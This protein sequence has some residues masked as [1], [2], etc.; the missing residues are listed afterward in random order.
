M[1][2]LGLPLV[3]LALLLVS[4][5]AGCGQQVQGLPDAVQGEVKAP[6]D[7]P[8]GTYTLVKSW[9]AYSSPHRIGRAVDD[10]DAAGGKALEAQLEQ[11]D[12]E[13][14]LFGPYLEDL[15][16]GNYVAFYRMKLLTPA[17]DDTLGPVDACVSY[18]QDLLGSR[19]LAADDLTLGKY[20]QVPLGFHYQSGKLE[21]R[22]TWQGTAGIRID[23]VSLFRLEGG[24]PVMHQWLVPQAVP[25]GEPK[26]LPYYTEPKSFP[27]IFP[28]SAAPAK[29]MLVC[30]LRKQ[31]TDVRMLIYTLQGLINRSQPRL[32]CISTPQ[33]E[34]WL[35]HMRKRGWIT[36]TETVAKPLDLLT[37][38][39]D[40]FKGVIVTDPAL[41][42]SKN[43]ATMLASVKS[44]LVAS[45][46][47][48]QE[49]NL[50]VLDDLRGRW[51]TS[52]E[53][54]RWA[55]D[56]LW[57][58]LNHHVI[59][60]SWPE[61]LALRDYLVENKVFIFWISGELDGARKYA[62]PTEEAKL[63]EQLLAKMPVNIPV[64]SYPWAGKGNGIG[65]GPGVTLFAEFGK[66]L[67]G[68]ID[69]SN[70]SV[71]SGVQIA[72]FK[73]P[74]P[75]PP[76]LDPNKTYLSIVISDGDNLPVLTSGNFPQLY[77]D[78]VRGQF[79]I[80]WTVSPSASML[81]PDILD[82]YYS[83]E[84]PNDE[85]IAAVSGIGYT[86]PDSYGKRYRDPDRQRIYDGFLEQT[87]E[88]M[89]RADETSIWPM[90]TTRP[91][92]IARYAEKIPFLDSMFLDYGRAIPA[93][94]AATY[95][96]ARNVPIF[97]A[98]TTWNEQEDHAA[99]VARLVS[100]VKQMTP[101]Q[102]PAFLHFFALNWFV[103][104]PL[105]QEVVKQLGPDY[106]FVRPTQLSA[107]W[108]EDMAQRQILARF[109]NSAAGI[110][111]QP[112]TLR[113]S[114]R[115]MM[116][117]AVPVQFKLKSGLDQAKIAPDHLQLAPDQE[118]AITVVGNP[119]ADRVAIEMTGEFG[120]R[121]AEVEVRRIKAEEII[122]DLPAGANLIPVSCLPAADLGH[123]SGDRVN[124][125]DAL[126]GSAWAAKKGVTEAT[127]IVFG[128][129]LPLPAGQYLALFRMKRT[130][131]GTGVLAQLDTCVAGG[132]PQTALRE[133]K[134]EELPVG[135]YR[136]VPI[137]FTHPGGNYE[138]RIVW[139]GA[140]SMSV[141]SIVLWKIEAK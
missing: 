135:Q 60:C 81:I 63:M 18:A 133:V 45:P 75:P 134:A 123:R 58:K 90:N 73:Q 79:P 27:D 28:R 113:G 76:K 44:G 117:K 50:P 43:V 84:T 110:E 112:L 106:V 8:T 99:R 107:L 41:P 102:K 16:P 97:R 92:V 4:A 22:Y 21:C 78:K 68:S 77:Q 128:P 48:A 46:R 91:A 47:I 103:D 72:Q 51:K 116:P 127:H 131:E 136:C 66:Y 54:Y 13:T 71:H 121:F 39:R 56:N 114:I 59:A 14:M 88:Y 6:A 35:D 80:G 61:H 7:L 36:T 82:W 139:S 96:T 24:E 3:V 52:V 11:D 2:N 130:D 124:D 49:L 38:F 120:T 23:T 140:A 20:V 64:M 83:N 33:D 94:E 32:Y 126:A 5:L 87:A 122:G 111:G 109:P 89:K 74:A 104:L 53:A 12:P 108:R 70:L 37:R 93:S 57:D 26:N 98:I 65:E 10:P 29:N 34:L 115:N 62:N 125:P 95:P 30:D 67:V 85:F 1:R 100:D 129:Y 118:A 9:Q 101:A 119:T 69:C 86:Y 40:T 42:A 17:G 141:D 137:S 19:D 105:L 132:T 25:S 138:T 15:K 31:R 55:F